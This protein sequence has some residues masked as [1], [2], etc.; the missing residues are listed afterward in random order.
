[1]NTL[2]TLHLHHPTQS[3]L[4]SDTFSLVALLFLRIY[5]LCLARFFTALR[6][7]SEPALARPGFTPPNDRRAPMLE[8]VRAPELD[9]EPRE[10]PWAAAALCAPSF[11][12]T[13]EREIRGLRA[14][15]CFGFGG[16]TAG[17]GILDGELAASLMIVAAAAVSDGWY[18]GDEGDSGVAGLLTKFVSGWLKILVGRGEE[19]L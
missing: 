15:S 4:A 10:T 5:S 7:I 3:S 13:F 9:G 18:A 8:R 14:T 12:M 1:M 16:M 6:M 17:R 2:A 11:A 19:G